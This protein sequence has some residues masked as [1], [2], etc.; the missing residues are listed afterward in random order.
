MNPPSSDGLP[1][2]TPMSY[3]FT[4]RFWIEHGD[5]GEGWRGRL[6]MVSSGEVRHCRDWEQLVSHLREMLESVTTT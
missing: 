3:L 6:E 2:L 5:E 4:V 1:P